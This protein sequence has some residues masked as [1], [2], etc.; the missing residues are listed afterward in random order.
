VT[1][2][3]LARFR[4][5]C[6]RVTLVANHPVLV[7]QLVRSTT[8]P[9]SCDETPGLWLA[10]D[11][12]RGGFV[13][14]RRGD[15]E[16]VRVRNYQCAA[17]G[18]FSPGRVP[19]SLANFTNTPPELGGGGVAA[20][21]LSGA[22]SRWFLAVDGA[23]QDRNTERL[24]GLDLR[25]VIGEASQADDETWM[26]IGAPFVLPANAREPSYDFGIGEVVFSSAA[27]RAVLGYDIVSAQEDTFARGWFNAPR[28]LLSHDDDTCGSLREPTL[29]GGS[30]VDM[31]RLW[32]L[33]RCDKGST[34]TLGMA[35]V[36]GSMP[37]NDDVLAGNPIASRV[38]ASDVVTRVDDMN[39]T[40]YWALWV[41]AQG[42]G[43]TQELHLFVADGPVDDPPTFSAYEGNPVLRSTDRTLCGGDP[44]CRITSFTVAQVVSPTDRDR[45]RFLFARS[46]LSS[47]VPVHDLV[48][49]EQP[50]S[51]G[52]E[53][54]P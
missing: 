50:A 38:I 33:Y 28:L 7:D 3:V 42:P 4:L 41:L 9:R 30:P 18:A 24:A 14:V 25:S 34:S 46:W 39:T 32:L 35:L 2:D 5:D 27:P 47:G 53:P 44:D 49:L 26:A 45:L 10:L 8:G 54:L 29:V 1:I 51:T 13:V 48:P 22:T 43:A 17:P 37:R 12:T 31:D 23:A 16:H 19:L 6:S 15:D 21:D 36:P 52:L 20:P 11:G 40:R